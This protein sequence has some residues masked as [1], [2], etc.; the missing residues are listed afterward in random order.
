[1]KDEQCT[2]TPFT[3]LQGDE[4]MQT[5][6]PRRHSPP[7][8]SLR[9]LSRRRSLRRPYRC[10]KPPSPPRKQIQRHNN[11]NNR[12]HLP[13]SIPPPW[14]LR[15]DGPLWPSRPPPIL[16]VSYISLLLFNFF[17][18]VKLYWLLKLRCDLCVQGDLSRR[19][20]LQLYK[21]QQQFRFWSQGHC[22]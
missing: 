17:V 5:Y 9:S 10:L 8:R 14:S 22:N 6:F 20:I 2:N 7:F 1:M 19:D 4:T 21:Y 3:G 16:R 12:S 13:L 11:N 15:C 18:Y